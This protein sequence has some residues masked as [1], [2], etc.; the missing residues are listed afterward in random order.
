[1]GPPSHVRFPLPAKRKPKQRKRRSNNPSVLL[2]ASPLSLMT[3]IRER[4]GWKI[5]PELYDTIRRLWIN[6]S[7]AEDARDLEPV[8]AEEPRHAAQEPI[9][10]FRHP[11]SLVF[12]GGA[13]SGPVTTANGVQTRRSAERSTEYRTA[14]PPT[15][16][17]AA[18][19]TV[20]LVPLRPS[21]TAGRAVFVGAAV[22]VGHGGVSRRRSG[23]PA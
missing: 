7:K 23:F 13:T 9:R 2:L 1:M 11:P 10:R 17:P 6:H 21:V 14:R 5:T 22:G 12:G 18:K 4:L 15:P 8:R 19:E 20:G 3:S 16:V